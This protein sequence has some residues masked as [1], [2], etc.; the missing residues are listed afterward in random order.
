MSSIRIA[1]YAKI[2]L[3]L[4][5]LGR[6]DDAYHD[7]ATVFQ[8]VT[9]GDELLIETRDRPGIALTVPGGGAPEGPE[10]LCWRAAQAYQKLRDWPAGLDLELRKRIPAGAG[11][12]GGSAN[13]AAVLAGLAELDPDP[14]AF[15]IL[16]RLAAR[17]GSDVPFCLRGGTALGA[18]RGEVLTN[19]PMTAA[20]PV[21]LVK[22]EFEVSTAEAY[23]MLTPE[24]FTSGEAALEMSRYVQAAEPL[25]EWAHLVVNAFAR[26]LTRR[27]PVFGELKARLRNLGAL[28]AEISGSGSAVFGLFDRAESADA[29]ADVLAAEGWWAKSVMCTA[30]GTEPYERNGVEL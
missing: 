7:L 3:C 9:L 24:D 26:P 25:T 20:H 6:R 2:N 28:A 11:L 30:R 4:E 21:C 23:G 29:V 22:P 14:P 8:S 18:G 16:G 12:A 27:W 1:A 19:W 17:L 15:E 10:N 5:V 13:A